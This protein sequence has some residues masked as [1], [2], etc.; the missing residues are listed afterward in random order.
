MGQWTNQ[1]IENLLND[2]PVEIEQEEVWRTS[3]ATL[4]VQKNAIG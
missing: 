4:L 3:A 2:R 1:L